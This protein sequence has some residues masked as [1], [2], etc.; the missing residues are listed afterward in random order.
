M[1]QNQMSG[2]VALFIGITVA[3][4]ATEFVVPAQVTRVAVCMVSGVRLARDDRTVAT[5]V[6]CD[7]TGFDLSHQPDGLVGTEINLKD[8]ATCTT[9]RYFSRFTRNELQ[10]LNHVTDCSKT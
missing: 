6:R 8:S 5:S 10:S 4:L 9:Y 2:L 7:K 1:N 3:G